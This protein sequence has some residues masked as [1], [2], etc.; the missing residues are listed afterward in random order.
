MTFW[1][2]SSLSD[3]SCQVL[4]WPLLQ[5]R[6]ICHRNSWWPFLVILKTFPIKRFL[7][8][9]NPQLPLT[10]FSFLHLHTSRLFTIRSFV[11]LNLCLPNC[12]VVLQ[13]FTD[14]KFSSRSIGLEALVILKLRQVSWINFKQETDRDMSYILF[15][16]TV[17]KLV[18]GLYSHLTGAQTLHC[19][20]WLGLHAYL[21]YTITEAD[22]FI[23]IR[24]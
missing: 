21:K 20:Q 13:L 3:L 2:P 24:V 16:S 19:T 10:G 23:D 5:I 12:Y 18:S 6:Y 17:S 14:Q 1:D 4:S 15:C 8:G 11:L 9:L 22:F 7:R